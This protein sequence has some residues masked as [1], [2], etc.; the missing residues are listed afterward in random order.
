MRNVK[1][2]FQA[3]CDL[4]TFDFGQS[5]IDQLLIQKLHCDEF[6]ETAQN[7]VFIGGPGRGKTHLATA[8][9]I[10]AVQRHGRRVRFLSTVELINALEPEKASG[11]HGQLAYRLIM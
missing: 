6:R 10:A 5:R 7:V 4:A 2:R 3:D 9:G 1:A 8:I 11:R